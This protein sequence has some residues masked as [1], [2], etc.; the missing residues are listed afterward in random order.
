MLSAR[1]RAPGRR[2]APCCTCARAERELVNNGSEIERASQQLSFLLV[3]LRWRLWEATR[4][5]GVTRLELKQNATV[6]TARSSARFTTSQSELVK[7]KHQLMMRMLGPVGVMLWSAA[8]HPFPWSSSTLP[9]CTRIF[10]CHHAPS[11]KCFASH[12]V[13]VDQ[14]CHEY[15]LKYT[16]TGIGAT[17]TLTSMYTP[18]QLLSS[19]VAF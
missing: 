14:E 10:N 6:G 5:S 19:S 8:T 18:L 2:V 16:C 3:C 4:R 15:A 17:R 11:A 9:A 13:T 1:Q 7:I 12:S